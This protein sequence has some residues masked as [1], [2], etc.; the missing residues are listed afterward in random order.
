MGHSVTVNVPVDED[1]ELL[2]KILLGEEKGSLS[3]IYN[4]MIFLYAAS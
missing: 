3:S 1:N 2:S 4:D